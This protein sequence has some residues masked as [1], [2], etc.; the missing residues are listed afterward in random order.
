MVLCPYLTR[1]VYVEPPGEPMYRH[2]VGQN[3]DGTPHDIHLTNS[4]VSY[5]STLNPTE[6]RGEMCAAWQNG[7]CVRI[8]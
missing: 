7:R 5:T 4:V 1:Q 8:S 6:C 3:D 2:V